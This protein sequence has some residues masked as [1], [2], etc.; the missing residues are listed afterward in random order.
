V[1]IDVHVG[2]GDNQFFETDDFYTP[3][4]GVVYTGPAPDP[5]RSM[6]IPRFSNVDF[7]I[8]TPQPGID[9]KKQNFK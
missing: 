5:T 4:P 3:Q 9:L 6:Q 2:V 1:T 8:I 7:H